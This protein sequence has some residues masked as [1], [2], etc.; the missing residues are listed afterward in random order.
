MD[1]TGKLPG[2]G[3]YIH[4]KRTCWERALKGPVEN[5]LKVEITETDRQRLS[6][7]MNTLPEESETETGEKQ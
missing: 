7:Y 3:A 4:G 5:A 1:L 2:R 6:D